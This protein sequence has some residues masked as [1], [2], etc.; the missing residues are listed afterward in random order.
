[1]RASNAQF[2]LFHTA[3][4]LSGGWSGGIASERGI[5]WAAEIRRRARNYKNSGNEAKKSLKTNDITFLLAAN[6]AQLTRRFAPIE[7]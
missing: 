3:H 7:R 2:D 5:A 1:M 6:Y 4:A